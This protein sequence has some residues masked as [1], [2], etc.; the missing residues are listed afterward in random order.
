MLWVCVNQVWGLTCEPKWYDSGALCLYVFPQ[1]T[2][3]SYTAQ[4]N[5]EL[6][7][8]FSSPL[9]TDYTLPDS[10]LNSVFPQSKSES[11]LDC[12]QLFEVLCTMA[13]GIL[14]ARILEWVDFPFSRGSSQPRDQTWVSSIAGRLFNN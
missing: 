8:H 13:H 1:E 3:P 5:C 6:S 10:F 9:H 2:F 12:V 14:Q 4:V 11:H 7:K